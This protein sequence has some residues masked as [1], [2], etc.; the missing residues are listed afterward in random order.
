MTIADA[1]IVA[2]LAQSAGEVR[3]LAA[4]GALSVDYRPVVDADTPIARAPEGSSPLLLLRVG[5][6]R[7]AWWSAPPTR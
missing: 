1:F 3:R 2:G 5:K 7:W 4:Q 6:H